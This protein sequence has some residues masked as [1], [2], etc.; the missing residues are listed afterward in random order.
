MG[1]YDLNLLACS[2]EGCCS[3]AGG[4]GLGAWRH[5]EGRIC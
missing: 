2:D 4:D 5:I 3:A 1:V